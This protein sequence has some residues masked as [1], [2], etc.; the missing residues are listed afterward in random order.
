MG[1]GRNS[2]HTPQTP[3]TPHPN[4]SLNRISN[5]QPIPHHSPRQI[6]KCAYPN[7]P[8]TTDFTPPPPTTPSHTTLSAP[9]PPNIHTYFAPSVS[10][11]NIET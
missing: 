5:C 2:P 3:P 8:D 10:K 9:P 7:P 6:Y 11:H 1:D 4:F